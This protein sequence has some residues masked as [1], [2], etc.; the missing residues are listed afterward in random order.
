MW[1]DWVLWAVTAGAAIWL[2]VLNVR[3]LRQGRTDLQEARDARYDQSRPILMFEGVGPH[4]DVHQLS[5]ATGY[6]FA[7]FNTDHFTI[8]LRNIGSG[9]ALNIRGALFCPVPHSLSEEQTPH[10]FRVPVAIPPGDVFNVATTQGAFGLRGS[11]TLTVG[12]DRRYTLYA[13]RRPDPADFA[14]GVTSYMVARLTIAYDDIFGRTHA[15][16]FD[17]TIESEWRTVDE[18][19]FVGIKQDLEDLAREHAVSQRPQIG[20]LLQVPPQYQA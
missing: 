16:I 6:F 17:Y 13:P 11:D 4:L 5:G 20:P 2:N 10:G 15:G 8:M 14:D 12:R 1:I 7:E 18:G 19:F 9:P 3:L